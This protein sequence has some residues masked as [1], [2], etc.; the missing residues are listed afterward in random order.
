MKR[1]CPK[2]GQAYDDKK[3]QLVS[4]PR[5]QFEG[6]TACCNPAGKNCICVECEESES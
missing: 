1:Y 6:S 4:C 5:C 3:D 2:C